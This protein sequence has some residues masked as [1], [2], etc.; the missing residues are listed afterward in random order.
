MPMNESLHLKYLAVSPS[1]LL[2][3]TAVNSVGFQQVGP[4][5]A[6]PPGNHP[7]RYLFSEDRGRTLSE[8]QLLYITQGS[9][10]FRSASVPG[11]VPVPAGSLILLF[12][13]EWHSY[14]PLEDTGWKEYWIGFESAQM[15]AWVRD[16]FFSVSKPLWQAGLHSDI[17]A[18]YEDAVE[19]AT[20]QQSGFQQRLGGIVSH[21][22]SLAWFYGRN[23][24]LSEV[25]ERMN[26]AKIIISERFSEITP[27]SL[28]EELFMGYSNFRRVF[29]Q[30]TGLSPAKYIQQVRIGR[31]KEAL[32]NTSK[33]VKEIAYETGYENEDYF[34]TAFRRITG[35]PPL[36]YRAFTQGRKGR[37]TLL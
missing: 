22:L 16:G 25:A 33:P 36:V 9:G 5:E 2:W 35:I 27:E 34:S 19:T 3:G 37:K 23:S 11:P 18:L 4:G 26:R 1:D 32:T 10:R 29:R 21:L 13:G 31:A 30:Y 15:D 20:E 12:P 24:E 6:Y 28:A 17:V 7:S 8:Y 14:R